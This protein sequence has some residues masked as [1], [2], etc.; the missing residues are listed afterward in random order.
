[1]RS[2]LTAILL[3]LCSI[4]FSQTIVLDTHNWPTGVL[5]NLT[6]QLGNSVNCDEIKVDEKFVLKTNYLEEGSYFLNIFDF[7]THRST[8]LKIT[9]NASLLAVNE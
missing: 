7:T 1:M 6:D 9:K 8:V 3:S 2:I 4:G 5:F